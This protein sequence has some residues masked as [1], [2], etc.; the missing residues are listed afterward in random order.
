ML[1]VFLHEDIE[2]EVYMEK[3]LGFVSHRESGLVCNLC[4]SLYGRKQSPH[5]WFGNFNHIVQSFRMKRN[6]TYHLC[7]YYHTSPRKYK[8]L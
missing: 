3:P 4:C 6:D 1:N 8:Y 7:F 5:V 2:E